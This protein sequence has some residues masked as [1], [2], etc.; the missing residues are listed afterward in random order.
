MCKYKGY[1]IY[2]IYEDAGISAKNIKD[3]PAFNKL[4]D[5]IKSKKINTTAFCILN[6]FKIILIVN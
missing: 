5:D 6:F 2:G 4:L 3:R 1:E